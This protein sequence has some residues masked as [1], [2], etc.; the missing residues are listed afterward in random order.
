MRRN[1][2]WYKM[3]KMRCSCA[4][5]D[6]MVVR[7]R[8]P[9]GMVN[10]RQQ[11]MMKIQRQ[12]HHPTRSGFPHHRH[13][14]QINGIVAPGGA[15][16]VNPICPPRAKS[17]K[18]PERRALRERWLAKKTAWFNHTRFYHTRWRSSP[19]LI[20]HVLAIMA[21]LHTLGQHSWCVSLCI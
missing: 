19:H 17:L 7:V 18:V 1:G 12:K 21:G 3:A 20:S 4:V 13:H 6:M 2:Q 10:Q 16:K 8:N 14:C 9:I 5:M 11:V 15:L